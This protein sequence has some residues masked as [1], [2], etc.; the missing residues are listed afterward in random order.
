MSLVRELYIKLIKN[1]TINKIKYIFLIFLFSPFLILIVLIKPI[2]FV[3]F[4]NLSIQRIGNISS[5]ERYLLDNI[6]KKKKVRSFD[7]WVIDNYICN[8]QSLVL[9][10]RKFLIIKE[11]CI[12]YNVLK[13]ISKYISICSKHIIVLTSAH[14]V[15]IDKDSCQ[16]NLT[17]KEIGK[18]EAI[19]KNFGIP[20]NAKIVCISGRDNLYLKKRYTSKDFSYHDYRDINV[21]NYIPA[22][23]ALI[24]KNYYVVRMGKF[25]NKKI[26]IKSHKFIDYPFHP[27]KNDFMDFFFAHKCYFWICS[28][29][30]LDEIAKVFRK[31][32]LDLNMAPV[33]GLKVTSKKTLLC[34]KIHKNYS[35]KKLSLNEIFDAGVGNTAHSKEFKRK[36]IR[37]NELTS[38]QIKDAV[39][40]M[41]KLMKNSW[42]IKNKNDLKLQKK[43]KKLYLNRIKKI[44]PKCSY[45][46]INALYSLVFLKKNP[47]F[48]KQ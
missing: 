25:S 15:A 36:K 20:A 17:R 12:F 14:M 1:L 34:S 2:F 21:K 44:D 16:L 32:L 35:N 10:K 26:N 38:G 30:G 19:L 46:K 29:T 7:I 48:L 23:K 3:R 47:W 45:K 9:L 18:G 22:I 42:K 5:A 31:P 4:G 28:N 41:T 37:L 43:F 40:E 13:L 24:K 6:H 39:L 27:L 33:A 8:Q 11:L